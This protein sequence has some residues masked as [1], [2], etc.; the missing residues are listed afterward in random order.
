MLFVDS[1]GSCFQIKA[2]IKSVCSTCPAPNSRPTRSLNKV[3]HSAAKETFLPQELIKLK[4]DERTH[5]STSAACVNCLFCCTESIWHFINK[6]QNHKN[7]HKKWVL[8]NYSHFFFCIHHFS[9]QNQKLSVVWLH[10]QSRE[11]PTL[12]GIHWDNITRE[13]S[14]CAYSSYYSHQTII[15]DKDFLLV[16]LL[17]SLNLQ[18]DLTH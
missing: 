16:S 5:N 6:H 8:S 18:N 2:L 11:L 9:G 17:V 3:E 15:N 12:R 1:T 7:M 13:F 10:K 4:S 14:L